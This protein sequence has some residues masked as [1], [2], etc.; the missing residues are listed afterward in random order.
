MQ[1]TDSSHGHDHAPG[2]SARPSESPERLPGIRDLIAVGSGKGGVGKSTVSVNLALALQ[3]VGG[4]IG[5]LDA[6]LFGP[7]IPGMLGLPTGQ[8]PEANPDR[9]MVPPEPHGLKVISMGML[10]GDDDP[11]ILRGPMVGKFLSFFIGSVQWGQLDA[12]ILD[13]PPGTG[14]TQ[15][16]LAQSFPLSGAIIVTT[17]QD[18]S[19]KIARRGLR[20]FET[21]HVPIL[22]IIEN[23]RTFTCPH[24]GKDTDVF[25]RGGGER[26][27]GQLGVPFLGAIPLDGDIVT[28]GDEG[29]PIV[30]DRPNSVAAQAYRAIATTLAGLLEGLP[31]TALRPFAWTW[32]TGEGE[33]AWVE[34]AVRPSGSRTTPVGFRRRDAR[35]LSLLWEDR[36]GDDF[37]VRDLR[38]ACPCAVC[39][40]ETSGRPLLDPKSV[41]PDITPRVISSVGNYAI[42]ISWSD[43][44]ST[45]IYSFEHLRALGELDAGKVMED[46]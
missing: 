24:C 26:M 41:R 45:G 22:G 35:T 13:L 19:L 32:E 43:S 6:D 38:L 37:D 11:A 14:D 18:V 10:R 28:G 9:R 29:R 20:M 30:V 1:T 40:E 5:L 23:M 2:A 8:Q 4:R 42:T 46:V 12:L 16:T 39:I 27:S 31:T 36:H 15:L 33:P 3:H 25:R 7:S 17:P 44:H 34:S 21:V